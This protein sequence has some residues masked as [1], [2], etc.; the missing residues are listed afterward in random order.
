MLFIEELIYL[1]FINKIYLKK[2]V[3]GQNPNNNNIVNKNHLNNNPSIW[4]NYY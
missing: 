3:Q 2:E 4:N 1:N